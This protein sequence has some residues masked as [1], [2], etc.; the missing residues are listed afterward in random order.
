MKRERSARHDWSLG[1]GMIGIVGCLALTV[2]LLAATIPGRAGAVARPIASAGGHARGTV[3]SYQRVAR[4]SVQAARG[5]LDAA[6]FGSPAP[7]HGVSIYRIVYRT[8]SPAGEPATASGVLALPARHA[9]RLM[10]RRWMPPAGQKSSC[11]PRRA[12]P[13]WSLTT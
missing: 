5:Y 11:S 12:T 13:P 7:R 10:H 4:L 6:G 1:R 9:R 2:G 3:I 8:V